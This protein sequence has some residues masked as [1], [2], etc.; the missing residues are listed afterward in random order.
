MFEMRLRRKTSITLGENFYMRRPLLMT[1]ISGLW[2]FYGSNA[3]VQVL[4]KTPGC[5]NCLEFDTN[6][7]MTVISF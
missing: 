2:N 1:T 4:N 6:D 3:A 7:K 5:T